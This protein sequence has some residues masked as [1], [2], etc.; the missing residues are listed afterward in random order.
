[1]AQNAESSA[2]ESLN[3]RKVTSLGSEKGTPELSNENPKRFAS[4]VS[5]Q[6]FKERRSTEKIVTISDQAANDY[7]AEVNVQV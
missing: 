3:I 1:M 5:E 2:S 4:L 6:Q 7:T